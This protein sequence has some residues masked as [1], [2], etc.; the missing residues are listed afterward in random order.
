MKYILEYVYTKI[1]GWYSNHSW[2]DRRLTLLRILITM[3]E[4]MNNELNLTI[5]I[6]ILYVV[7]KI[8]LEWKYIYKKNKL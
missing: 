7:G 2:Q 5:N 3:K 4:I 8:I 6:E 1:C